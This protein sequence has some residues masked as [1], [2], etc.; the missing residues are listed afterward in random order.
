MIQKILLAIDTSEHAKVAV[1]LAAEIASMCGAEVTVLHVR[2]W[3]LGARGPLDEGAREAEALVEA[4]L[5]DLKH[6]GVTAHGDVQGG[7]F[8]HVARRIV[9]AAE[10]SGVDLIIL[11]ARGVSDLANILLG[12]VVHKVLQLSNA[13]VLVAR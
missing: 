3:L 2:E 4:A 6:A 7:Y 5:D 1:T 9:A 10:E 8:G 12:D 11:G 13:P